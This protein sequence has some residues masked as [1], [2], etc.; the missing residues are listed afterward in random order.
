MEIK[1]RYRRFENG[2]SVLAVLGFILL[3][4]GMLWMGMSFNMETS[5]AAPGIGQIHNF[6]LA[7]KRQNGLIGGGICL[8]LGGLF[9]GFGHISSRRDESLSDFRPCPLCAE[10][11]RYEAQLCKHCGQSVPRSL[12]PDSLLEK[13]DSKY[14]DRTV[15]IALIAFIVFVLCIVAVGK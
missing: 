10:P 15:I 2:S 7:E 8:L 5:I 1:V 6:D 9:L 14:N 4:G 3:L 12:L 13:D 11:I